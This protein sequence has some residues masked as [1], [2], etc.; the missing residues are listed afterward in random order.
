MIALVFLLLVTPMAAGIF[1]AT[2]YLVFFIHALRTPKLPCPSCHGDLEVAKLGDYCPDCGAEE[3]IAKKEAL[4]GL[5]NAKHPKCASCG[6]K[7]T[8]GRW[9]KRIYRIRFCTHCGVFLDDKGS[10]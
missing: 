10:V 1:F 9:G 2:G 8:G 7:F 3:T 5:I 6:T 4:T